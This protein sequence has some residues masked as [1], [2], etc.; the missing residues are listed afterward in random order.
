M[1]KITKRNLFCGVLL[2]FISL[3]TISFGKEH[4]SQPHPQN[5]ISENLSNNIS[6][7]HGKWMLKYGIENGQKISVE[8]VTLNNDIVQILKGMPYLIIDDDGTGKVLFDYAKKGTWESGFYHAHMTYVLNDKNIKIK[9]TKA[10]FSL[11]CFYNLS[12]GS[13]TITNLLGKGRTL[14][15]RKATNQDMQRFQKI[16]T[17]GHVGRFSIIEEIDINY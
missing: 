6:N 7:I 5:K 4:N 16:L 11:N 14:E 2:L 10:K 13:L 17:E 12:G 3:T 15:L 8:E 1:E 9:Y